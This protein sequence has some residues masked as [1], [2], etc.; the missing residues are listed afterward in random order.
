MLMWVVMRVMLRVMRL[1]LGR[2]VTLAATGAAI[3]DDM[4]MTWRG[5]RDRHRPR[6]GFRPDLAQRTKESAPLH[7]NEPRADKHD[8][9]VADDLD[10]PTA[11]PI[12]FAVAPI[13]TAAIATTAVATCSRAEANDSTT[14]RRQD[15]CD[16]WLRP[17]I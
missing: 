17:P 6:F 5:R 2:G 7:P 9:R 1:L 8:E 14:P 15:G 11:S 3:V 10:A 4:G 16:Y 12:I 13:S